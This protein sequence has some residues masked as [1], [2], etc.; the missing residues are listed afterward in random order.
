M[1]DWALS[2]IRTVDSGRVWMPP[3]ELRRGVSA[4][5]GFVPTGEGHFCQLRRGAAPLAWREGW[6]GA[7]DAQT[8]AEIRTRRMNAR[9]RCGNGG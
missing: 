9:P 6:S 4:P 5:F 2:E 3:C 8:R 7:L 1:P